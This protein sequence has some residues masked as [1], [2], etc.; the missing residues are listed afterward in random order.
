MSRD[1][2]RAKI[3]GPTLALLGVA[4][5]SAATIP[6]CLAA[7]SVSVVLITAVGQH[8]EAILL[9]LATGL[10]CQFL[11]LLAGV[12][13]AWKLLGEFVDWKLVGQVVSCG[14]TRQK[15]SRLA[16]SCSALLAIPFCKALLKTLPILLSLCILVSITIHQVGS[17]R[18]REFSQ[19]TQLETLILIVG[20]SDFQNKVCKAL[21]LL[22]RKAP[23]KFAFAVQHLS[24]VS[25]G[26]LDGTWIWLDLPVVAFASA[27]LWDVETLAGALVHEAKHV[28][29][30]RR[31]CR[32]HNGGFVAKEIVGTEAETEAN[33]MD[34]ETL[35]Q[36]G[37]NVTL[38]ANLEADRGTY[39]I[40][41]ATKQIGLDGLKRL[42]EDERVFYPIPLKQAMPEVWK[43]FEILAGGRLGGES[44][45]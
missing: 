40:E 34:A 4:V 33:Q 7:L 5:R 35:L 44:G 16:E 1:L 6:R 41:F 11:M 28:E 26:S 38:A 8:G 3:Q 12:P 39:W 29:Q 25:T 10:A 19:S 36:V 45:D 42:L 18:Q 27:K 22:E 17:V 37:G 15:L 43:E 32:L 13:G 31:S 23:D 21:E 2:L 24:I 20:D 30:Q 9:G 14:G